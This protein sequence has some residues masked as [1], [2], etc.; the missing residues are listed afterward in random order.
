MSTL[1]VKAVS[2]N[3]VASL[4]RSPSSHHLRMPG[5][6]ESGRPPRFRVMM[7]G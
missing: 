4:A 6:P 5:G 2:A 1:T 7:E 3:F